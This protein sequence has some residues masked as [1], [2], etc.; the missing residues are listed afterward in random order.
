MVDP[1]VKKIKRFKT[2]ISKDQINFGFV[3]SIRF[4]YIY[5]FALTIGKYF[6]NHKFYFFGGGTN[7]YRFK[8]L[9]LDYEN[10]YF[11]GPFKSPEDLST[12]YKKIDMVVSCY[13]TY[14][15]NVRLAEPNKLYES[16]FFCKPIIVSKNTYLSK[17]VFELSCGYSID[18]SNLNSIK[19]FVEKLEMDDIMSKIDKISRLNEGNY[20]ISHKELFKRINE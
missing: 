3:G 11:N 9:S 1:S 13:D 6:P 20:L 14:S 18:P 5:N 17:R 19:L 15:L 4:D 2:I 8:K 12:I 10:I 7:I 16:I